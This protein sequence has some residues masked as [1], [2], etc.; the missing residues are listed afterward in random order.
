MLSEED[1]ERI[2]SMTPDQRARITVDLM[3]L[4]WSFL[5]ALSPQEAQRRLDLARRT[6]W[7]PPRDRDADRHGR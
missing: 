2:R 1:I 4:G 3:E 6:P 5:R 7:N